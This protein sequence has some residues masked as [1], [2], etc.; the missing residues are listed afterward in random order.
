MR[1]VE[2]KQRFKAVCWDPGS[3]REVFGG[4]H[5]TVELAAQAVAELEVKLRTMPTSAPASAT[6]A[7]AV[8]EAGRLTEEDERQVL[9]ALLARAKLGETGAAKILLDHQREVAKLAAEKSAG[10]YTISWG[11]TTC[12][13]K[14]PELVF[15]PAAS[16]AAED[17]DAG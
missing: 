2:A 1:W 11:C 17:E 12:R 9:R 8:G 10:E 15:A 6:T 3:R 14:H 16:P 7:T 5:E 4:Y 13:Y